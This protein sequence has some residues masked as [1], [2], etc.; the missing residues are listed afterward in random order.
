VKTTTLRLRAIRWKPGATWADRENADFE[1]QHEWRY[2][3]R[4]FH[5]GWHYKTTSAGKTVAFASQIWP[6][7]W[8]PKKPLDSPA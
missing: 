8:W 3:R 4:R 7:V 2:G 6:V 1:R 5:F